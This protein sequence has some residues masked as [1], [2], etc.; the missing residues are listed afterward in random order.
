MPY[1]DYCASLVVADSGSGPYLSIAASFGARSASEQLL[2]MLQQ[3][4]F[5]AD[6]FG[7]AN[8]DATGYLWKYKVITIFIYYFACSY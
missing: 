7:S 1:V 5:I 6:A 8:L 3:P 2:L 4:L